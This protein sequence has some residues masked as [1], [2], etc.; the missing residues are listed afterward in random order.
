M[1][2]EKS[3]TQGDIEELQNVIFSVQLSHSTAF[4]YAALKI[5]VVSHKDRLDS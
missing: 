4:T 2:E 1:R 3:L 5:F